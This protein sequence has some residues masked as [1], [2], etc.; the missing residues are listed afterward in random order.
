MRA[1]RSRVVWGSLFL[2]YFL[3][4]TIPNAHAY[5]D[6][7]SGSYIFQ[8]VVGAFLGAAVAVRVFWR[9]IWGFLTRKG[10]R[11]RTEKES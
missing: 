1:H 2:A 10:S 8:L 7:N 4:V 9:R 11:S 5:I 6:P 3:L